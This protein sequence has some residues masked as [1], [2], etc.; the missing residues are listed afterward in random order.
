M[1]GY[2]GDPVKRRGQLL[3]VCMIVKDQ[4]TLH[5]LVARRDKLKLKL[6]AIEKMIELKKAESAGVDGPYLAI[7]DCFTGDI[8]ITSDH[9][10]G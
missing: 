1:E 4:N 3:S 7:K 6:V 8:V 9:K 2:I 5:K 10:R